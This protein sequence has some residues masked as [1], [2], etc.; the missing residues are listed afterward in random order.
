M[1]ITYSILWF[2]DTDEFFES[3]DLDPLKDA[4]KSWGFNPNIQLVTNPD[5]F[6][7]HEPFREY[8]LIVVDYNLEEYG[9][10]GEEFI[11]K[12]REHD[13]YT[14]VIFYSANPVSE[15][16][17]AVR[18]KELEGVFIV[19]RPGV[20]A[21][22]KRVADQSVQKILDLEN[23]RGIVMAEVG[24]IDHILDSIIVKG[25]SDLDAEG[26]NEICERFYKNSNKQAKEL[27][28]ALD[29][30]SKTPTISGLIELASDSSKR[31]NNFQRLARKHPV[32]KGNGVGDYGVDVLRPR[33][34]LAHSKPVVNKDGGYTFT[35]FN[36]EYHYNDET[37][38]DLR[39]KILNYKNKFI[40]I[41]LSLDNEE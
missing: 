4:I 32:L 19:G 39:S 5:D 8:D 6:M 7:S 30:F 24:D 22:I 21:K 27:V 35:H 20:I 13:V 17:D 29:D 18:D 15:L 28:E 36:K 14:E 23:V 10:H 11:K 26:I 3:L 16:W 2:D 37:S 33:N 34:V 40:E 12:I 38:R 25:L 9:K 31:W 41:E 1:R